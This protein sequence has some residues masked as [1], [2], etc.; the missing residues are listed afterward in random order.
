MCC[1]RHYFHSHPS[2]KCIWR[3]FQEACGTDLLRKIK[4]KSK[5]KNIKKKK[6]ERFIHTKKDIVYDGKKIK[7]L[8][9]YVAISCVDSKVIS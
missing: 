4:N 7:N 1:I 3:F 6:K 9:S 5:K 8:L 2:L